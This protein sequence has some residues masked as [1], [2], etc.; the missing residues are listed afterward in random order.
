MKTLTNNAGR[1]LGVPGRHALILNPG[2][3]VEITDQ[4]LA[5][6]KSNR[7]SARWLERGVIAVSEDGK[8]VTVKVKTE[9]PKSKPAANP[10]LPE[11]LTGEGAEVH[12]E[13]GGWYSV[14]ING[15]KVTDT[16]LRKDEAEDTAAEYE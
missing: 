16:N 13:G 2:E 4:Q 3:S 6:I 15:F 11:G 10:D 7:V 8:P 12:H 14:Y 5:D 9:E 1:R